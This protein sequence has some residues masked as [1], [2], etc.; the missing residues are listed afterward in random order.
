MDYAGSREEIWRA[1]YRTSQDPP[2]GFRLL[3]GGQI[4]A[5]LGDAPGA[6]TEEVGPGQPYDHWLRRDEDSEDE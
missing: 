6:H 1:A 4:A 5:H 2:V 3:D